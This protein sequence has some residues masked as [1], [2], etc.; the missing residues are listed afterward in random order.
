MNQGRR[1]VGFLTYDLQPFTVEC[2]TRIA[3]RLPG[4][5]KAYP[6]FGRVDFP[7]PSFAYRPSRVKGRFFAVSKPGVTPEGLTSSI[8]W[9]G[10]WSCAWENDVVVLFGIQGGSALLVTLLATLL[11]RGVV[12]V[13]QTLPPEGEARRSW[14]ILWLKGW[15]LRRCQAHVVQTPVSILA[16]E[17]VYKV[18]KEKM[19]F[20]PFD[21]GVGHFRKE[22]EQVVVSREALRRGFGWSEDEVVFVFVGTMMRF[23]GI[24]TLMEAVKVL[25]TAGERRVRGVCIGPVAPQSTEMSLEDY[26]QEARRLGV[27]ERFEFPGLRSLAE[28]AKVYLAADVCVLPT[29]KDT[30]GKVLSEAALAGLPL[31]TTEACGAAHALV[32]EGE[33]GYIV[34]PGDAVALAGAMEKLLSA[35]LRVRMGQ[36]AKE[37]TLAWSR[38]DQEV[39]GYLQAFEA[40]E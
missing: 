20:A 4:R 15:I 3:A 33:S 30:W 37:I 17:Q 14:W 23:K 21:G 26:R 25:Q 9:G 39:N 19:F 1:K 7:G 2:L 5:L 35:D 29:R 12:S 11:G 40:L 27:G 10:A 22:I 8:N 32:L 18:P 31:I 38:G 36:R 24:D 13:N 6:V 34:P 28:L 16:M